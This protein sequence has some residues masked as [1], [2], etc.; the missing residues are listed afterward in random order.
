LSV[1]P[2]R[3]LEFSLQ[4]GGRMGRIQE[5]ATTSAARTFLRVVR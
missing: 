1:V 5:L 4:F 2:P 3:I